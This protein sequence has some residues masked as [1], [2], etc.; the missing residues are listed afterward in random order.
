MRI[1]REEMEKQNPTPLGFRSGPWTLVAVGFTIGAVLVSGVA[2]LT[3]LILIDR[4]L[5]HRPPRTVHVI[6]NGVR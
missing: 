1:L 6:E 2:G 4:N 5:D 3:Q